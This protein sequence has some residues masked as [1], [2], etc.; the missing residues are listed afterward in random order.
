MPG[1]WRP[2]VPNSPTN[3]ITTTG[4]RFSALSVCPV[5]QEDDKEEAVA[6]V[7]GVR[8]EI[9]VDSAAEKS[10][11]PPI[12]AESFGIVP[13]SQGKELKFVSASGVKVN[14][15]RFPYSCAPG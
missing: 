4:G 7:C 15:L 8:T 13:V 5:E 3:G 6:E 11:C 1:R 12:W 2:K 9:T 10:V 14:H